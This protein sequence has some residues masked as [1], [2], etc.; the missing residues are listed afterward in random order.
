MSDFLPDVQVTRKQILLSLAITVVL[1]VL[2]ACLVLFFCQ[3][4]IGVYIKDLLSALPATAP[5]AVLIIAFPVL[6]V[7]LE[8]VILRYVPR[9]YWFEP[10]NNQL[11]QKFN[12]FELT[13]IFAIGAISEEFL[14]RGVLQNTFGFW[15]A[16]LL[17]VLIHTRYLKRV[18]LLAVSLVLGCGLGLVYLVSGNLW[19]VILCH[20]LLNMGVIM[21]LKR[22]ILKKVEK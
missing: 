20:F 12:L 19:V 10:I 9:H 11:A 2:A 4:S 21:I 15:I 8:W 1:T 16:T 6:M 17:F 3:I 7:G 5:D 22:R 14:F 13:A 18:L